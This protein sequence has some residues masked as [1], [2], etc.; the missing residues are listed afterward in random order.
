MYVC[1][2]TVHA[3]RSVASSS[4]ASFV[5]LLLSLLYV[6]VCVCVCESDGDARFLLD[7]DV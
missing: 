4:C 3:C 1:V 2:C 5:H 6:Y 7:N